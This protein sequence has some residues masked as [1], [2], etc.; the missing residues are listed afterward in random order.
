MMRERAGFEMS[1]QG[2]SAE[3]ATEALVVVNSWGAVASSKKTEMIARMVRE[4]APG[5][6]LVGM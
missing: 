1:E 5:E 6:A 4:R 3:M 2:A